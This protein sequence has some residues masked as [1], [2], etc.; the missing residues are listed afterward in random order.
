M[1]RTLTAVL[2]ALVLS[3]GGV[4]CGS[5]SGGSDGSS[6]SSGSGG[7]TAQDDSSVDNTT[8][9]TEGQDTEEAPDSSGTKAVSVKLP[10][11]P[12]GG[13]S[14]VES[15][16]LQCA[17]VGWTPEPDLPD[18]IEIKITGLSLEPSDGFE[19]SSESCPG[20]APACMSD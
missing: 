16:T 18:G 11:L 5:D 6:G 3:V 15:A 1:R 7:G 9:Q 20:D 14:N 13:D 4:A 10:G 17:D 19:V 12:V 8:P 2:C